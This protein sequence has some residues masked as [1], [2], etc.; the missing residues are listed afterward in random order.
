MAD[1]SMVSECGL[2][3]SHLVNLR[4]ANSCRSRARGGQ[5]RDATGARVGTL[6]S[7]TR[8]G[9]QDRGGN[10]GGRGGCAEKGKYLRGFYLP[11]RAVLTSAAKA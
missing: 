9:G 11:C 10:K 2:S 7:A 5:D 1:T 3:G 6:G 8:K 4:R